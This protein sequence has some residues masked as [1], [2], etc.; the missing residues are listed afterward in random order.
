MYSLILGT[1]LF[2]GFAHA[3]E[4]GPVPSGL[5]P[6][7]I[8]RGAPLTIPECTK[9]F[10]SLEVTQYRSQQ[11][12][13]KRPQALSR[14]D[15]E[16]DF[17]SLS[18]PEKI[19]EKTD[20]YY[21]QIAPHLVDAFES[22]R[23]LRSIL[24]SAITRTRSATREF[25]ASPTPETQEFTYKALED[26]ATALNSATKKPGFLS[27]LFRKSLTTQVELKVDL[28]KIAEFDLFY[29]EAAYKD[30][31]L[32]E[33]ELNERLRYARNIARVLEAEIEF[34]NQL[35]SKIKTT[36]SSSHHE[37]NFVSN[38]IEESTNALRTQRALI[39]VSIDNLKRQIELI[40]KK[41]S[42]IAGI[43]AQI[44]AIRLTHSAA[45]ESARQA[46]LQRKTAEVME[47]YETELS[48][49]LSDETKQQELANEQTR[50]HQQLAEEALL[51]EKEIQ[52]QKE[53]QAFID[54]VVQPYLDQISPRIKDLVTL[55]LDTPYSRSLDGIRDHLIQ[56][57]HQI[58]LADII[59][60]I[61]KVPTNHPEMSKFESSY[62]L[63][64][65]Q[66]YGVQAP[67]WT[68][69]VPRSTN[70]LYYLVAMRQSDNNSV[71]LLKYL[72]MT[73][74]KH[75]VESSLKP[76]DAKYAEEFE[77]YISKI[78]DAVVLNPIPYKHRIAKEQRAA[79]HEQ[80]IK[81][82]L[83][84]AVNRSEVSDHVTKFLEELESLSP[85]EQVK[86]IYEFTS[87]QTWLSYIDALR[88]L[89]FIPRNVQLDSKNNLKVINELLL[90]FKITDKGY[91]SE[92]PDP[93]DYTAALLI[94]N[95]L[96]RLITS[97]N[98]QL[99]ISSEFK[100][101]FTQSTRHSNYNDK[102][103]VD[104]SKLYDA[105]LSNPQGKSV[106]DRILQEQQ[107]QEKHKADFA[108]AEAIVNS[109]ESY[110]TPSFKDLVD[111]SY[112]SIGKPDL[113]SFKKQVENL[114][115]GS[116]NMYDAAYAFHKMP[117][118]TE[119]TNRAA[120]AATL[121][122]LAKEYS[123]KTDHEFKI[124]TSFDLPIL[125]LLLSKLDTKITN[126]R[127]LQ[128]LR[129]SFDDIYYK[130]GY[131]TLRT[132]EQLST[133]SIF[134]IF[135]HL[136]SEPL[137]F[138][139]RKSKEPSLA[140]PP[141]T[142]E[143]VI[144][145]LSEENLLNR[146]LKSISQPVREIL[147]VKTSPEIRT[148]NFV[149]LMEDNLKLNLSDL[150]IVSA[151]MPT[152]MTLTYK[153]LLHSIAKNIRADNLL[154]RFLQIK[155]PT[156][157]FPATYQYLMYELF[158]YKGMIPNTELIFIHQKIH[159]NIVGYRHGTSNS[160]SSHIILTKNMLELL[161]LLIAY[162]RSINQSILEKLEQQQQP[163]SPV[164][165]PPSRRFGTIIKG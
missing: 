135:E 145:S 94:I 5:L 140:N 117:R 55:F 7:R 105:I 111:S 80:I 122:Q 20:V 25:L 118:G 67:S 62:L 30:L 110:L 42:M 56:N 41:S 12:V 96:N 47:A 162:R 35:K 38:N 52:A 163:P 112:N 32:T 120:F 74:K 147:E 139:L 59:Y 155:D 48:K 36:L 123:L 22:S 142:T 83:E 101:I 133:E 82:L 121:N 119:P 54:S 109:F 71:E 76:T 150:V 58:S 27:G 136:L 106:Y 125:L 98:E 165:T 92:T 10:I 102:F 161:D 26:V 159:D 137:G 127:I 72:R 69:Q 148:R 97:P 78:T 8:G 4:I 126:N 115:I 6:A 28:D 60:L 29:R 75:A 34:L 152:S 79:A 107:K 114:E 99:L 33:V 128:V 16:F 87:N 3:I 9:F 95:K 68:Q 40:N 57:K 70:L 17:S 151:H 90:K 144:D 103:K 164:E 124:N 84:S 77:R 138:K 100:N 88:I 37:R 113:E 64:L 23:E 143:A 19:K 50:K 44:D 154:N 158:H 131:Y 39:E 89:I 49:R 46:S 63:E 53:E 85:R 65:G 51:K 66:E 31:E 160:G 18:I 11:L 130:S 2:Y 61:Y 81:P 93:Y 108:R 141:N 43:E 73:L 156:I 116:I 129:F 86:R 1:I 91:T 157:Y 24:D 146:H 149:I 153:N 15:T 21:A 13:P 104:I 14:Y 132:K 134:N 45:Y